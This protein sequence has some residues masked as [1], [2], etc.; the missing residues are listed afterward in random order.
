MADAATAMA[1][2]VHAFLQRA[3]TDL[4]KQIGPQLGK[5][6]KGGTDDALAEERAKRVQEILRSLNLSFWDELPNE[7]EK[8]LV[9]VAQDGAKEALLSL[10]AAAQEVDKDTFTLAN[11]QAIEWAKDRAAELVGMKRVNGE[12]VPN[13]NAQWQI[14]TDTREDIK[15]LVGQALEEGWSND[16]LA[17]AL[18]EDAA[19]SDARAENI[20]RTETARA[21]VQGSLV[22]YKNSGVVDRKQ[23]LTAPDCCDLCQELDGEIVG[24]EEQFPKGGGDGAPLHPQCRCDV[25]PVLSETP[26][27]GN[28]Q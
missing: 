16:T 8:Y 5:V 20:A 11:A 24:L 27:E 3:A 18:Q 10:Q 4:A 7:V 12:F 19:F 6:A 25:L 21:D 2:A 26:D 23:W 9:I 22:G 14:D 13:P 17:S 15:D 1:K 28:D